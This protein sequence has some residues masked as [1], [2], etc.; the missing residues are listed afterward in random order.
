MDGQ[1]YSPGKWKNIRFGFSI[2]EFTI[3]HVDSPV[4]GVYPPF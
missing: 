2:F 4:K 1:F 3:Q